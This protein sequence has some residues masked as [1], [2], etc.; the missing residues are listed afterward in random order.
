[1]SS[2][3]TRVAASLAVGAALAFGLGGTATAAE[4]PKRG[5]ILKFVIPAEP[6]SYDGHRETTFALIHP[7]APFYSLLI[8]PNPDNPGDSSDFT[9]DLCTEMPEPTDGGKKYTF[10]LKPG[11]TSHDGSPLTAADV[12]ATYDKIIFPPADVSSARKA[13]F[14]MVDN[15][16][17]PDDQTVVFNLHYP[18]GAFIPALA[19]PFNF[20][21]QKA[22]LDQDMKWYEKNILGSGPFVFVEHQ[23][24]ALFTG[25][26]NENFYVEGQPYLDGF[27]GIIAEQQSL[28]VQAIRGD[29][30]AIEFRGFPPKS[31]DDLVAALGDQI[32]V[33]E[34][35]WN[36]VLLITPN[37]DVAPFDDVRARRAL[38]L[39]VDRWGGSKYLS[40]IAIVKTVGGVA[41]PGH[42][43]A[44]T[45]EE[46][47]QLAGYWPDLRKS[48][49]EAKKLLAD[50]GVDLSK[51]YVLNNRGIDQPYAIVGTW[52]ID[53]WKQVGLNFEQRVQPT[54]PFYD[55]LRSKRD[56][57]VSL[58]FNCQSVVNPLLDIS[59][60]LSNDVSDSQYGGYV[61]RQVDEL[62]DKMNKEADPA[63]QREY[64]REF[65]RLTLDEHANNFITLWWYRIIPHRSYLKGW[66]ISPSHYVNNDLANV[67]ID[68]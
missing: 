9:C 40:E 37:H 58:D 30:A 15:V 25:K 45:K 46:L 7:I 3:F 51:T 62:F 43:L 12:K 67:W 14:V 49:D 5:G 10:K 17:A 22:K 50:A 65:E 19:T 33:Q 64:M 48:R 47:E 44:A 2:R 20:I 23:A 66:A 68:Q 13:Y 29:R 57:S 4:T 63:K 34:S 26:R 52:L 36:C 35:D 6:P 27:E 39:A 1:M 38:T 41:F 11:V 54:G 31:R 61:D 24:G 21:Y 55:T 42:P 18:S 32:T 8:R 59:K 16:E 60:F 56:F 28:R 53:Q